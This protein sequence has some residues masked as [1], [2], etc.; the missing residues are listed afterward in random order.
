MTVEEALQV[1]RMNPSDPQAWEAIALDVYQLLLVY[2]ASLLLTFKVVPGETSHDIV[3]EVLLKF[4][5]RWL[6]NKPSILS[7]ADLHAYLRASCRNL[8][9]DRYRRERNAEQLMDFL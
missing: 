3:Q 7:A 8:L 2:V 9:I 4:Y 1:L 6:E 5:E